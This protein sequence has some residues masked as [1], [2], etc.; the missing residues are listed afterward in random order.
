MAEIAV[1]FY[2]YTGHTRALAQKKAKKLNADLFELQEVKKRSK[3]SAFLAGSLAAI[4]NKPAH[5]SSPVPD[6]SGYQKIVLLCP[7]WAGHLAPPANNVIEA[8]PSHK[9]VQVFAV[10]ASGDSSGSRD[11]TIARLKAKGCTA[12][13]YQDVKSSNIS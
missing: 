6:L 4:R 12:V 2:S 10:S 1:I 11:K 13:Q 8:L 9:E 3:V 7:I 5:L